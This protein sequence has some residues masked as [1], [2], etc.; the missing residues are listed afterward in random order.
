MTERIDPQDE[1]LAAAC[2]AL[3]KAHSLLSFVVRYDG[4]CTPEFVTACRA[5][6]DGEYDPGERRPTPCQHI[7]RKAVLDGSIGCLLCGVDMG[8]IT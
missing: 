4:Q 3:D 6:V 8:E 2:R 5:W 1:I 7:P